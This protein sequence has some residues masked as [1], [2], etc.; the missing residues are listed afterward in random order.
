MVVSKNVF[1]KPSS[2]KHHIFMKLPP[3][4]I[5]RWVFWEPSLKVRR[6]KLFFLVMCVASKFQFHQTDL[7]QIFVKHN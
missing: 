4:Y 3:P 2:L 6:K 1:V 5:R 7:M